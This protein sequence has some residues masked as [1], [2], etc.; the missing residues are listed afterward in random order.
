MEK[1]SDFISDADKIAQ[2]MDRD[3]RHTIAEKRSQIEIAL[4]SNDQYFQQREL[5]FDEVD[6]FR[7][8]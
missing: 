3:S 8:S 2:A 5:P 1:H 7:R 4:S 6:E